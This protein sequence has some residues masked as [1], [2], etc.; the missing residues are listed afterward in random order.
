MNIHTRIIKYLNMKL[1][2]ICGEIGSGKSLIATYLKDALEFN[3]YAFANPLKDIAI[4]MGFEKKEVWGTQEQKMAINKYWGIS[5]REFLQ[6]FGTEIGR[7]LLPKIIPD[8]YMGNS[9][10]PWIRLF[11]IHWK[12]LI[13][14]KGENAKLVVSDVRFEDEAKTIKQNGGIII[15]LIRQ[16]KKSGGVHNHSSETSMKTINADY[17][18][19]NNGTKKELFEKI[20]NIIQLQ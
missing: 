6:K 14:Y 7:N 20:Y 13:E 2:G 15:R 1:I 3:E 12:S 4:A 17:I 5:A 16:N 11:E 9:G 8:M 18:I 19:Y 10:S